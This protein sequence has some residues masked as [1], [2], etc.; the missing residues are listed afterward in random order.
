MHQIKFNELI[1]ER[2]LALGL[3]MTY[4]Q[5]LKLEIKKLKDQNN[6]YISWHAYIALMWLLL[7]FEYCQPNVYLLKTSLNLT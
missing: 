1:N 4:M 6:P 2:W 3:I 7:E 5:L